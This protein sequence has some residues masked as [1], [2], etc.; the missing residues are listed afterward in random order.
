MKKEDVRLGTKFKV[1][2]NEKCKLNRTQFVFWPVDS[3]F[4]FQR[5]APDGEEFE[6]VKSSSRKYVIYTRPCTSAKFVSI[7]RLSDGSLFE[8]FYVHVR[9]DSEIIQ[10][11]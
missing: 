11:N 4:T 8:T 6:I 2:N 7:K 1:K 10:E 5:N 9:F 3:D